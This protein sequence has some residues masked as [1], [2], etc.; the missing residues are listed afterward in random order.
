MPSLPEPVG[1]GPVG[2]TPRVPCNGPVMRI[3]T[4]IVPRG[5]FELGIDRRVVK[6]DVTS[7]LPALLPLVFDFP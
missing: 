5:D 6:N 4:S 2:W 1:R 3:T 7:L